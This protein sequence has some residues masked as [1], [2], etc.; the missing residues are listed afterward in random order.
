MQ[1]LNTVSLPTTSMLPAMHTVDTHFEEGTVVVQL[2]LT[3][4]VPKVLYDPA[5]HTDVVNL[6]VVGAVHVPRPVVAPAT[7]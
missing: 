7:L 3:T 4:L 1:L 5:T 6:P 2:A